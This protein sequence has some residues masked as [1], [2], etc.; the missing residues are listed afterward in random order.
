MAP[1]ILNSKA[2]KA[3]DI[4]SFGLMMLELASNTSLP[5]DG[6]EWDLLRISDFNNEN[7][8]NIKNQDILKLISEMLI[9]DS[10]N[11]INI[12]NVL[13]SALFI[14]VDDKNGALKDF[15]KK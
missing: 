4:F 1:D 5:I 2:T 12:H 15:F 8:Y 7:N 14:N 6:D 11:R 3:A 10:K 9:I 13:S